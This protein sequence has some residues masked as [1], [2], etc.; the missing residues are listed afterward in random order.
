MASGL[1]SSEALAVDCEEFL[2]ASLRKQGHYD[3]KN[4][5]F[6]RFDDRNAIRRFWPLTA[7]T[8]YISMG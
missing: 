7:S 5:L 1:V 8:T 3:P 4:T 2:D 6:L